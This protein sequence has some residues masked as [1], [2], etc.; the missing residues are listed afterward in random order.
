MSEEPLN[1][2]RSWRRYEKTWSI[3][4]Q[5][6]AVLLIPNKAELRVLS[7]HLIVTRQSG[8]AKPLKLWWSS[9]IAAL[10][11]HRP[12][13]GWMKETKDDRKGRKIEEVR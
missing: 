9:R 11:T 1:H 13:R 6:S 8:P 12:Q 3:G 5:N 2:F 4:K 10:I 7:T